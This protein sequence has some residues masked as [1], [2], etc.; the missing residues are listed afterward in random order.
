MPQHYNNN[1]EYEMALQMM[2]QEEY[3]MDI[4]VDNGG[5]SGESSSAMMQPDASTVSIR[6]HQNTTEWNPTLLYMP[7]AVLGKLFSLLNPI[8]ATCL[9]LASK[10]LYNIPPRLKDQK[11]PSQM[12]TSTLYTY[13][14][15][16]LLAGS[17]FSKTPIER[18]LVSARGCTHCVPVRYFPAH[19]ELH[20]HL[21][22]WMPK[23]LRYCE[24]LCKQ[25]TTSRAGREK[26]KYFQ[27]DAYA[28]FIADWCA[29]DDTQ[30]ELQLNGGRSFG[31]GRLFGNVPAPNRPIQQ[32]SNG[33][34]PVVRS[35][36]VI[37]RYTDPNEEFCGT[38]GVSYKKQYERGRMRLNPITED[39]VKLPLYYNWQSKWNDRVY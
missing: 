18:R 39:G 27:P 8:D 24:G 11:L 21:K 36:P 23:H 7:I 25:F 35:C 17:P 14:A 33:H 32:I 5:N 34:Y 31:S 1:R 26:Q 38:C 22:S 2:S 4:D 19:C 13:P 9:S 15:V 10:V 12:D 20:F 3:P 30:D 6:G 16:H 29:I 37:G 28:E